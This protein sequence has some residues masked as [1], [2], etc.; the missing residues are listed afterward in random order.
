MSAQSDGFSPLVRFHH[1]DVQIA[2]GVVVM[3]MRSEDVRYCDPNLS[4]ELQH[5]DRVRGIDERGNGA[6]LGVHE[7]VSVVIV[8]ERDRPVSRTEAISQGIGL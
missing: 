1:L 8:G 3:G 7:E 5:G 4:A 6:V 2:A